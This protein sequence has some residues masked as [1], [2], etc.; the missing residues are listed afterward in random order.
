MKNLFKKAK[1]G[2]NTVKSEIIETALDVGEYVESSLGISTQQKTESALEEAVGKLLSFDFRST[3]TPKETGVYTGLTSK[4]NPHTQK[5]KCID[6]IKT[7]K[8]LAIEAELN[9]QY[10]QA[11]RAANKVGNEQGA[12]SQ[13]KKEANEI[14]ASVESTHE[15]Y[16]QWADGDAEKIYEVLKKHAMKNSDG[17]ISPKNIRELESDGLVWGFFSMIWEEIQ[18]FFGKKLDEKKVSAG[19]KY[20]AGKF[21][22]KVANTS[23]GQKLGK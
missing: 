10:H 11:K 3:L 2:L 8:E 13:I 22:E 4:P 19:D 6:L 5:N 17:K 7:I 20:T 14:I 12:N 9:P 21:A 18:K 15:K 16:R 23:A 1:K